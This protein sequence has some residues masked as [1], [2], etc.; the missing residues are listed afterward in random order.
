M[1]RNSGVDGNGA[2]L[3]VLFHLECSLI[4]VCLELTLPPAVSSSHW[5]IPLSTCSEH[6]IS[7]LEADRQLFSPTFSFLSW[8]FSQL[9]RDEKLCE[10]IPSILGSRA[11]RHGLAFAIEE[12][13]FEVV[14]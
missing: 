5:N 14:F 6:S 9:T 2:R 13:S 1:F 8:V 7:D 11:T 4:N 3:Q 12:P 10:K